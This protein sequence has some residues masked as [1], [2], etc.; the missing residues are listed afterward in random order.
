MSIA[1]ADADRSDTAT[2]TVFTFQAG[3]LAQLVTDSD[4]LTFVDLRMDV[5]GLTPLHEDIE[6]FDAVL[7]FNALP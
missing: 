5:A 4:P 6:S 2:Q 3:D 7:R 1:G